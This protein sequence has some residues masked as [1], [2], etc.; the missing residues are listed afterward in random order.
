MNSMEKITCP[1]ERK[2][3]S[4]NISTDG[5]KEYCN[6]SILFVPRQDNMEE[7]ILPPCKSCHT[8]TGVSIVD[9]DFI[10]RII[11]DTHI[12]S[13]QSLRRIEY[14]SNEK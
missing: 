11:E 14:G 13:S 5:Q 6:R 3:P 4:G 12:D 2:N 1:G 10:I 8:I 7:V 9:G